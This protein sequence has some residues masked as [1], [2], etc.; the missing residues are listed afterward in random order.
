MRKFVSLCV[1][2]ILFLFS[3]DDLPEN[4]CILNSNQTFQGYAIS[5][6]GH[7]EDFSKLIQFY[8]FTQ[9]QENASVMIGASWRESLE[10][11]GDIPQSFLAFASQANQF[12]FMPVWTMGWYSEGTA[13]LDHPNNEANNSWTNTF[14]KTAFETMILSFVNQ[15]RPAY[16]FVSNEDDFYYEDQPN[17][18]QNWVNFYHTL[19]DQIKNISPNTQVGVTFQYEHI[20]GKGILNGWN[21]QN[22]TAFERYNP[23]KIDIYG[24]TVYPFFAHPNVEAIP[25]NYLDELFDHIGN[26]PYAITETGWPA[27]SFDDFPTAWSE[28]EAQQ[29][30]FAQMILSLTSG[31][32]IDVLQW[33]YLYPLVDTCESCDTWKLFGSISLYD[34]NGAPRPAAN[35]WLE[36]LP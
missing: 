28:S 33:L 23:D 25:S 16:L 29:A 7:P 36:N 2:C 11:S 8:E 6:E 30:S 3:C 35:V 21:V 10:N 22:W 14:T 17:D 19:Y 12:C 15:V 18:H 32:P 27:Q 1:V 9:Q 24:F 31:T 13:L 4:E 20:S 34:E 26:K 5:P